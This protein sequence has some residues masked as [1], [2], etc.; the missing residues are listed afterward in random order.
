[1]TGDVSD[2]AAVRAQIAAG[3]ATFESF[4][5]GDSVVTDP[6]RGPLRDYYNWIQEALRHD[7]LPSLERLTLERRRDAV[8]R[9]L[10]YDARIKGRFAAAYRSVISSG[11]AA[12]NLPVPDY[13]RLPRKGAVDQVG[14][15]QSKA[16][17][18]PS[19][20][21]EALRWPLVEGLLQLSSRY[22]PENWI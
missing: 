22:I 18:K 11:Y 4:F 20:A 7:E 17:Q 3:N 9:L 1:M 2:L 14:L 5:D 12:V 19:E 10:F 16:D 6:Q 8:I 13:A 21:A 15:F